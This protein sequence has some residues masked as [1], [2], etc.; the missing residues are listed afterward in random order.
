MKLLLNFKRSAILA[1]MLCCS[2]PTVATVK[3]LAA[4]EAATV[5]SRLFF[6]DE[7]GATLYWADMIAGDAPSLS[8][9]KVVEGFPKLDPDKQSLVQMRDASGMIMVGVRDEEDGQF[10]SGWVLIDS[11]VREEEHGDHS[12]WYYEHPPIVRSSMLDEFQ[13]NPAHLYCYDGVFYLANDSKGGFTRL[14]PAQIRE[15]DDA[16]AIRQMAAFH[17]GGGG[18]ITMAANGEVALST[19]VDR[20]GENAGRIDVTSLS[21]NGNQ[22]I[23]Y[24]FKLDQSG[25]HG[26]TS[27]GG[28]FFFAPSNGISWVDGANLLKSEASQIKPRHIDMGKDGDLPRRTGSFTE[29]AGHVFFV[30]GKADS[31]A[32]GIIN[33]SEAEPEV[34][35]VPIDI[36]PASRAFGPIIAT[37]RRKSPLAFVFHDHAKGV[38]APNTISVIELDP[39]GDGNFGDAKAS[40]QIEVGNSDMA[41]HSGHH[42]MSVDGGGLFAWVTNSGDRSLSVISLRDLRVVGT[43]ELPGKPGRLVSIGGRGKRQ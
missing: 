4:D 6:Q 42:D 28:K 38:E 35:M 41:G 34:V 31:T 37:P 21:P 16:E 39:N 40:V 26:A 11:G 14:N 33:A 24:S 2:F 3:V 25:L 5:Q 32:M 13:G 43:H 22:A 18:H 20:E 12:H 1:A 23:A 19:W 17:V 7:A 30:T 9:P 29:H 8:T 15:V 27:Q 10:Q 36:D